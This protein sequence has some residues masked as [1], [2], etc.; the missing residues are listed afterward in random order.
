M[1]SYRQADL[2]DKLNED[3]VTELKKTFTRGSI[4]FE[5]MQGEINL[6]GAD[7]TP[8]IKKKI[9]DAMSEAGFDMHWRSDGNPDP[10]YTLVED[11][12]QAPS[13]EDI[14]LGLTEFLD[15]KGFDA[16]L[17]YPM[18]LRPII[19]YQYVPLL[20]KKADLLRSLPLRV[21]DRVRLNPA[22]LN[23]IGGLRQYYVN[24]VG[25]IVRIYE[26]MYDNM[27]VK[28]EVKW[29]EYVHTDD[30]M[31]KFSIESFERVK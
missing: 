21:G 24:N 20:E 5:I 30:G 1:I 25:S 9:Y 28:A 23:R 4:V 13:A 7:G 26:D 12:P 3:K 19:E 17:R 29:D 6:V 14:I 2:F 15:A 31:S 11:D 27:K 16:N 8:E 18:G 10:Y 22:A